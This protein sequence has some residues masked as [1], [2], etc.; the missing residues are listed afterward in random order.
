L[1][2][3]LL[4]QKTPVSRPAVALIFDDLGESL[5]DLKEIYSLNIPLTVSIIPGLKFSKNIAHIAA[6]CGFS[7]MI[8][9]PLEPKK[10]DYRQASYTFIS[11]AL[12]RSEI[13]R[14]LRKYLNSIQIAVGV[15]N[16]MGSKATE[17]SELMRVVLRAVKQKNLIFIDSR[18]SS[19]SV[20]YDIAVEEGVRCAYNEWF[21]DAVEG[22]EAMRRRMEEI[23]DR[24]AQNGKTIVIAHPRKPT[25]AF[26]KKYLDERHGQVDFITIEDY[27]EP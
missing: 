24:A 12:G 15:N 22:E 4:R 8:H 17:D 7:V 6:R 11:A 2:L 16:H 19:R 26:L 5:T 10:D 1:E 13:D 14:L 20:A 3:N 23:V 25:I 18:T 21:L 9:L 27:F